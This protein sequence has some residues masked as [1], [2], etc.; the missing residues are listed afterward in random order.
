MI[1]I[2][3]WFGAGDKALLKEF[4]KFCRKDKRKM[5]NAIKL[6]MRRLLNEQG[7]TDEK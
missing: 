4:K 3:V 6:A 2:S 1:T 5:S 7:W